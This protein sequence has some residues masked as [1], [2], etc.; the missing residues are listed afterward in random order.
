MSRGA[1]PNSLMYEAALPLAVNSRSQRRSF[2]PDN[3]ALF[4][5]GNNTQIHMRLNADAFL[6]AA[7]SYLSFEVK[8]GCKAGAAAPAQVCNFLPDIG[9]L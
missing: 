5:S 6:D 8:V 7:H 4:S 9:H 3:G 2:F 1:I